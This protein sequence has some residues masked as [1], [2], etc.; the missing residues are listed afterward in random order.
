L[1]AFKRGNVPCPDFVTNSAAVA[2]LNCT[3]VVA[4]Q[5]INGSEGVGIIVFD[6]GTEVPP[7]PLYT[8]YVPKRKEFRVH[9]WNGEVIDVQEKRKKQGFNGDRN[10]FV[11]N[12]N[13]GYVFCRTDVVEPTDLRSIA[14]NAVT[15]IQRDYGAVDVIWN[16]TQ[17]KCYVLEV[18]SRPGMEGTTVDIYANAILKGVNNER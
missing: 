7:A 6:K 10:T 9:I 2:D 17:N 16:E 13:N 8:A 18:N 12:T 1:E 14:V 15:A 4:R 11:R 3:K 5:V